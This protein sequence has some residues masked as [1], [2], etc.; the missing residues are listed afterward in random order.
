MKPSILEYIGTVNNGVLVLIS[1]TYNDK[2][3]EGTFY[4]TDKDMLLTASEELEKDLGHKIIEDKEYV[5]ILKN[6][7]KRIVPYNEIVNTLDPIDFTR[8][9]RY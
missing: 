4:Y 2:Y 9:V 8:W 3:Y 6:I 1:I 5:T 7:L